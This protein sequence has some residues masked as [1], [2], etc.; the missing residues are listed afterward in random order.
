MTKMEYLLKTILKLTIETNL[1]ATAPFSICLNHQI[2]L[3]SIYLIVVNFQVNIRKENLT[4][5]TV[6]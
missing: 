6:P 2:L 4:S 1:N 3:A 5:S